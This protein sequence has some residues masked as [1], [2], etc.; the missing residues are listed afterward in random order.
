MNREA[1]SGWKWSD[2]ARTADK[3]ARALG[4]FSIGLGLV[5]L[6]APGKLGRML[7]LQDKETLLRVYG[8]REIAAGV[9]AFAMPTAALWARAAGDM[10]DLGTLT[11]GL[12]SDQD[13]QKRNAAI[14]IAAVAGIALV[15]LLV[16]GVL[17]KE[18]LSAGHRKDGSDSDRAFDGEDRDS[19]DADEAASISA[20]EVIILEPAL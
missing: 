4:W 2:Y 16:A 18:K 5:E 10:L 3:A 13:H 17:T 20:S 15:D 19:R 12:K 6:A 9:G 7:G 8:G 14:A 1:S 11:R